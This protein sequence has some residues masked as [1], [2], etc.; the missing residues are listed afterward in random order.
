MPA[1]P[2]SQQN[3]HNNKESGGGGVWQKLGNRLTG[4]M[5]STRQR[6]SGGGGVGARNFS[7]A[8]TLGEG[9]SD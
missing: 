5:K 7:T 1:I 9:E 4:R 3:S 2:L 8:T 6:S